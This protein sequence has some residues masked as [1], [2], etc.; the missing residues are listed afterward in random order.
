M[1]SEQQKRLA[2]NESLF[3]LVN[4]RV[5]EVTDRFAQTGPQD[6][7]CECANVGCTEHIRLTREEYERIRSNPRRF[8]IIRGHVVPEVEDVVEAHGHYAVVEKV[9]IAGETAEAQ[10]PRTELPP[11]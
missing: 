6:Y 4:E 7:L 11:D 5:E 2:A 3:R 9:G 8:A 1:G 10:D